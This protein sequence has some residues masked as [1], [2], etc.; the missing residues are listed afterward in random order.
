MV[1]FLLNMTILRQAQDGTT[2]KL[3]MVLLVQS[4]FIMVSLS[5]HGIFS[6]LRYR[7][8]FLSHH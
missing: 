7:D 4:L 1:Y 5:N 8:H 2:D 3:R 6:P